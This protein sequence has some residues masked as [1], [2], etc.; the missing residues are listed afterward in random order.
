M[1]VVHDAIEDGVSDGGI[2]DDV[3][4]VFERQLAGDEDGPDVVTVL[5][6]FEEIASLIGIEGL[7]SP[8]VDDEE[9]DLGDG[10][11]HAGITT[12]AA[13]QG[14]CREQAGCSVIRC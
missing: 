2:S 9:L 1:G 14:E 6:D 13:R 4:P 5:D 10:F 7:R 8:I 3:M 11:Q 12:V